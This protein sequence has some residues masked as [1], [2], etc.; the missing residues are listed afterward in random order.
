MKKGVLLML[1]ILMTVSLAAC[2]STRQKEKSVFDKILESPVAKIELPD[3][4]NLNVWETSNLSSLARFE[5]EETNLKPTNQESDWLYRIIY[6][7]KDIVKDGEEIV[8]SFHEN[9]VQIGSKF[10]LSKQGVDYGDILEWAEQKF[11]YLF[12]NYTVDSSAGGM[13]L[14]S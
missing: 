12:D 6:N 5:L 11:T 1:A 9:Y 10:Y 2:T 13:P 4:S 7:P 3:G 14:I 8:V